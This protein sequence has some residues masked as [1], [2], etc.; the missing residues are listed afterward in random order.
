LLTGIV[1]VVANCPE[2]FVVP[3]AESND[4]PA[5]EWHVFDLRG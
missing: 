4:T 1:T 3:L 5:V 2:L